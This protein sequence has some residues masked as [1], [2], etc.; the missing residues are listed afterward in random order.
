MRNLFKLMI[1]A[2]IV[3]VLFSACTTEETPQNFA[4]YDEAY[5]ALEGSSGLYFGIVE[6]L[7]GAKDVA[8]NFD[9][10][11][12]DFELGKSSSQVGLRQLRKARSIQSFSYDPSTGFWTWDTTST[13][14]GTITATGHLRFT[15]RDA[16]GMPIPA[17][18][19]MEYN[20]D[21]RAD[22]I[23]SG[24]GYTYSFHLKLLANLVATGIAAYRDST[25][26][27]TMNGDNSINFE[28]GYNEPQY[29]NATF[30]YTYTSTVTDVAFSTENE[31]PV[32]GTIG[33]TMKLKISGVDA[34]DEEFYVEGMITFDGTN[35]AVMEFGG[36][37]F[38]IDLDTGEITDVLVVKAG[39]AARQLLKLRNK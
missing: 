6:Q 14:F 13:E 33:F 28:L 19:K 7:K 12:P 37:T 15:P 22:E 21:I 4:S 2:G 18:D 23:E 9:G 10:T 29:G 20:Q 36:Y 30:K 32:G 24:E 34:G 38:H 3:G 11:L 8:T 16:F 17:T 27:L 1:L 26:N 25:G 5:L 31:Y 39:D 35:I